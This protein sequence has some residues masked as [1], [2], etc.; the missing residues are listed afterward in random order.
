MHK[1]YKFY[2]RFKS[3]LENLPI[4]QNRIQIQGGDLILEVNRI[5]NQI[6][7]VVVNNLGNQSFLPIEVFLVAIELM[8]NSPNNTANLGNAKA[9]GPLGDGLDVN[10]IEGRIASLVY[11]TEIGQHAFMRITPIRRILEASLLCVS[12]QPGTLTLNV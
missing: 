8:Y 3:Y 9:N 5:Q 11:K 1:Y 10:S 2:Q 4:G 12:H 7:G 6:V